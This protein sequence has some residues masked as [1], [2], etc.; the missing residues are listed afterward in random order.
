M[1]IIQKWK[2]RK[3]IDGCDFQLASEV[4]YD[5]FV[6]S[7]DKSG[8][9]SSHLLDQYF[10]NPDKDNAVL[11]IDHNEM[12]AFYFNECKPG[13]LYTRQQRGKS[14]PSS[15]KDSEPDLPRQA[16]LEPEQTPD[17]SLKPKAAPNPQQAPGEFVPS[18]TSGARKPAGSSSMPRPESPA[19]VPQRISGG[20]GTDADAHADAHISRMEVAAALSKSAPEEAPKQQASQASS[21]SA[22]KEVPV[23]QA[24]PPVAPAPAPAPVPKPKPSPY[25]NVDFSNVI[26]TLQIDSEELAQHI[27]KLRKLISER[28]DVERNRAAL[29][30]Y[31]EAYYEFNTAVKLLR[32]QMA[33]DLE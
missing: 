30:Q 33:G 14:K 24:A 23:V 6:K 11:L 29:A 19:S 20:K 16:S 15:E 7:G 22:V 3:I 17:F 4:L 9:I 25:R 5:K 10:S 2:Y 8:T 26:A 27:R 32:E 1:N 13:G 21:V 12:M 18:R 31:E 28:V